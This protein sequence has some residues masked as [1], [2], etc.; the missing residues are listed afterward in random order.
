MADYTHVGRSAERADGPEKVTGGALYPADIALPGMLW[1]KILRSPLPHARILSIDTSRARRIRGVHAILTGA[2]LPGLRTGRMVRDVPLLAQDRVRFLGEK[3]AVVAAEDPDLAEEALL[4]IDVDYEELPAVF[5]P[6]EALEADSPILHEEFSSY[7]LAAQ[8]PLFRPPG[9]P[10]PVEGPSN[11]YSR[12]IWAK[13][14]VEEGFAQADRVIEHTFKLPVVHQAY[15]EPHACLVQVDD[16]NRVQVW[17]NN[18]AP[19]ILRNQLAAATKLDPANIRV[20]VTYIGGDFGGKGSPMDVPLTYFLAKAAGR[21]VKLVM[22]YMEEFVAGDPRHSGSITIK[23]GVKR[24]GSLVARE[25]RAIFNSGAYAAFKPAGNL[26]GTAHL[27]GC[28]NIPNVSILGDCVYTNTIPC[29]HAR[30]PGMPQAYFVVESHMDMIAAELGIDPVELRLKNVVREGDTGPTG[31]HWQQI[32]AEGTLRAAVGALGWNTRKRGSNWGRGVAL[33]HHPTGGGGSSAT[34]TLA[35]DG[36]VTLF[37]PTFDTGTG[38]HTIIRQIVA[39]ELTVPLETIRV[40]TVSTDD[41]PFDGGSGASRVTH[42]AGQAFY[43]AAQEGRQRLIVHAAELMGAPQEALILQA[44]RFVRGSDSCGPGFSLAEVASQITERGEPLIVHSAYTPEQLNE[45]TSFCTEAAEVEV[46]LETGQITV[47][48]LVVAVDSGTIINP[49]TY[50]GQING[51]AMMGLGYALMEEMPIEE[52]RVQTVHFGDYKIPTMQ[53][54]PL[55]T[56]IFIEEGEGPIPYR[57]KG[58]GETANIGLAAAV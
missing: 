50:Q 32:K 21:P 55:V 51:G 18:K 29:G 36:G 17:V 2:D 4:L 14:N 53:D 48:R 40:V 44:G 16:S 45:V 8:I 28:Y 11:L 3:V 6:L 19:H 35:A 20:N 31:E 42:A 57:G 23:S 47:H 22:S 24:D 9:S 27:G 1:A 58:V 56:T 54:I 37:S 7:E 41:S 12:W 46:D 30:A 49:V 5:D 43:R 39:E 13:G 10:P 52:G 15:L 38:I 25:A 33:V 34:I 26:L